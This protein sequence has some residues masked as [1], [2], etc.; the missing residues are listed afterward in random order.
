MKTMKKTLAALSF[1]A[2]VGLTLCQS[3]QAQYAEHRV[4]RHRIV[5]CYRDFVIGSYR[6]HVYHNW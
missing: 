3:A 2:V 1:A 5:K 6:C 4:S